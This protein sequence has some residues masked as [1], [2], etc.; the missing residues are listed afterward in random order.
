MNW[1][2]T[3]V[4]LAVAAVPFVGFSNPDSAITLLT[5]LA[6]VVLVWMGIESWKTFRP[7]HGTART[8]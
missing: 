2:P 4:A 7:S 5:S 3:L 1:F 8:R 6:A